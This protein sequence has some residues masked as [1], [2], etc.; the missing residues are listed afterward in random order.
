MMTD[1][2][3]GYLEANHEDI[4]VVA[5]LMGADITD[6]NNL[7]GTAYAHGQRFAAGAD[8]RTAATWM[9]RGAAAVLFLDVVPG[10]VDL[11]EHAHETG[12]FS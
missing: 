10:L 1:Q 6:L 8:F 12:R 9:A 4:M 5:E 7:I 11:I 3:N 2:I